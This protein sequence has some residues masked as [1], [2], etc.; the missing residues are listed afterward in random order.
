MSELRK[1]KPTR[2]RARST[3]LT[4]SWSWLYL[5]TV[6][7]TRLSRAKGTLSV[8]KNASR[9]AT[10]AVLWQACAD[11]YSGK[12]G[13]APSGCQAEHA[14]VPLSEVVV[15]PESRLDRLLGRS[16]RAVDPAEV[17]HL[18]EVGGVLR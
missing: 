10:T 5:R 17:L 9:A 11:G 1:W 16:A 6:P 2:T 7:V 15:G 14:V 12:F 3:S 8:P 4:T 13:V 18:V